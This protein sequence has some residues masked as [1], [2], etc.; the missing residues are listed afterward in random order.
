MEIVIWTVIPLCALGI[1]LAIILFFVAKKF[2][3]EEDPRIDEVEACL[4]GANCGGC[5]FPGCRGL[6]EAVVKSGNL[7][8]KYCPAGGNAAMSKVAAVMG[9]VAEEKEPM[10]AVVRCCGSHDK[11][12]QT[13]TYDGAKTCAIAH[14]TSSGDTG[15]QYG[16]L[17]YGDCVAGCH[18]GAISINQETGLPEID[19]DKCGGCGGCA[20]M[21]PRGVIEVRPRGK[22]DRRVYVGCIN[23]D[24]GAEAM[25]ACKAACI[26]CGKCAKA[27]PFE[28]ITV[29][30]N[31]AYIDFTKCKMCRK[32][33]AEC[34]TG[35]INAVN[36]PS[37]PATP[38]AP[39][40]EAQPA[41]APAA[42]AE[43]TVVEN[44]VNNN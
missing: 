8:G 3:V 34:P 12:P 24:K 21:C 5:G 30:N 36:F 2:K 31:V 13:S 19:Y 26:G 15:C 23:K 22:N 20:K 35:A 39:K 7:D 43:A 17:G 9:L 29:E 28:A 25:K 40:P 32:C 44:N 16:C 6:S 33:V 10:V 42:P 14:A 38:P 4:P 18:F 37:K 11:R 1:V 41:P 27:C